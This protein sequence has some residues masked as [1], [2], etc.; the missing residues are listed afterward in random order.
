MVVVREKKII[1]AKNWRVK[2]TLLI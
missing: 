2:L 1:R